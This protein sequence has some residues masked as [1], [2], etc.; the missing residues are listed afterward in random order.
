MAG[1]V[2]STV[3]AVISISDVIRHLWLAVKVLV[4]MAVALLVTVVALYAL[5]AL[6]RASNTAQG[7]L[8]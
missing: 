5:L 4:G 3:C 8:S 7:R 2:R 1:P 6:Y